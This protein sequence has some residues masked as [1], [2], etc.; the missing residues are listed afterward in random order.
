MDAFTDKNEKVSNEFPGSAWSLRFS[1]TKG[2]T[3]VDITLTSKSLADLEQQ[4]Q[5]GFKEE[6]TMTLNFP[7][8]LLFAK[9]NG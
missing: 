3:T 7:E 5:M 6:F 1:E 4:L 9:K 8:E 2:I